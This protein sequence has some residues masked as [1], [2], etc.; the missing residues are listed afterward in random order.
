MVDLC[1]MCIESDK[2][3]KKTKY[4]LSWDLKMSSIKQEKGQMASKKREQEVQVQWGH[5]G[6]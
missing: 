4:N 1:T 5:G 6:L 2:V 3:F